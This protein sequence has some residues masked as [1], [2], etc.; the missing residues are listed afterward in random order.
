MTIREI[1]NEYKRRLESENY[2]TKAP[3]P[4][5]L[6]VAAAAGVGLYVSSK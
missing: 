5:L 2:R 4:I 3:F 1:H 6:A